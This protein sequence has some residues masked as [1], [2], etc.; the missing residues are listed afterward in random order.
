MGAGGLWPAASGRPAG[1]AIGQ[2][3]M[4]RRDSLVRVKRFRAEELKRHMATLDGMRADVARK[5]TDLE[6]S[7]AR[8]RQRANDSDLGRLAFPSFLKAMDGRR[9]NLQA[10]LRE[11]ER[12]RNQAQSDFA[13]AHQEL[14]SLELANEQEIRRAEET[15]LRRSQIRLEDIA[16]TRQLRKQALRHI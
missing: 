12:E 3:G 8:E 6:D 2:P 9:E 7:I 10:T 11:I 16:L 15:R 4:N 13:V 5:L 14:K 1:P